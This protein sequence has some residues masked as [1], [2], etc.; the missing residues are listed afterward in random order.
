MKKLLSALFALALCSSMALATVPYPQNCVVSPCDALNGV[1]ICPDAPSVIPASIVTL[2]IRNQA[3]NPIPNA[4][5]NVTFGAGPLCI[6][7]TMV[8]NATTIANGT[9]TLTMR[10]GGCIDGGADAAVFRA[11][12]VIVRTFINVKSPDWDG[13]AG[14]CQVNLPDLIRFVPRTDNC[15]NF[16]NAGGNDIGDTILFTSGYSPAHF[17]TPTP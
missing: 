7:T 16:D 3:N 10:G 14:S 15:F 5:V 11:N 17:C 2:T 4:A 12:G 8:Y 6:C 13:A 9:C 1:V